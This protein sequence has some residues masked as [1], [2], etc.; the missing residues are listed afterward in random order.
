MVLMSGVTFLSL[1]LSPS[2]QNERDHLRQP[3]VDSVQAATLA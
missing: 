3:Y 2:I 1:P